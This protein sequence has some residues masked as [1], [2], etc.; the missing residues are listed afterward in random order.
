M[1]D[2]T[3]FANGDLRAGRAESARTGNLALV[4]RNRA[5]VDAAVVDDSHILGRTHVNGERVSNKSVYCLAGFNSHVAGLDCQIIEPGTHARRLHKVSAVDRDIFTG[6]D[7][8]VVDDCTAGEREVFA[9]F[10]RQLS[11]IGEIAVKRLGKRHLARVVAAAGNRQ[12]VGRDAARVREAVGLNAGLI[13]RTVFADRERRFRNKRSGAGDR[14]LS[15]VNGAELSRA[16]VFDSRFTRSLV[17]GKFTG[18]AD[19]LA[20]CHNKLAVGNADIAER[21]CARRILSEGA[22]GDRNVSCGVERTAA[23]IDD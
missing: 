7:I 15:S 3:A 10:D 2:R 6:K 1:F 17:H 18:T 9:A 20:A 21:H 16:F 14:T 12:V 13:N 4:H 19:R 23:R 8:A 5:I 11:V 22:A